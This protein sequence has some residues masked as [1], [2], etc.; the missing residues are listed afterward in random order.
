MVDI[1]HECFSILEHAMVHTISS[2]CDV[3]DVLSTISESCRVNVV[4]RL[5]DRGTKTR[6]P[7]R[8]KAE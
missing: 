1:E 7:N 4:M 2:L 3:G 8:A 5:R 6:E